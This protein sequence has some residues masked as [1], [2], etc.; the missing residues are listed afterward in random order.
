MRKLDQVGSFLRPKRLKTARAKYADGLIKAEELRQIEDECIKEL[1]INCDKTGLYYLSDGDF[2]RYSWW[3]DFYWGFNGIERIFKEGGLPFKGLNSKPESV[4]IVGKISLDEHPCLKDFAR[5]IEIAKEL[6]IDTNRLKLTVPS[7]SLLL[8][9]LFYR[10]GFSNDMGVYGDDRESLKQDIIKAYKKFYKDFYAIGGRYL[11]LDDTSFGSFCDND[12]SNNLKQF[13]VDTDEVC[14]E[15]V[16]MINESLVDIPSDLTIALHV[17]R[18]NFRSRFFASGGYS[19]V[20]KEL[21]RL[22]VDK[23]FLEFD[24][25]RA[26]DF[27]PLEHIKNQIVVIGL[28]T[29]KFDESPSLDELLARAMEAKKYL[30]PEQIEFSTQC[31]FSS[32]E[33]GNE[34]KFETQWEKLKLLIKLN[35]KLKSLAY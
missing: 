26:G 31:G 8:F 15:F 28:L 11:H 35:E 7:P 32:S 24:S 25:D 33:E 34:I 16:D 14:I 23:F 17:C 6:N 1:L 22:N 5:L 29:T 27:T 4:K 13:G 12:F 9:M 2:R 10:A 30:K 20:I 19:R 3:N 18:G 21:A